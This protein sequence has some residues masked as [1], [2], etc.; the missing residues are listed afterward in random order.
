VEENWRRRQGGECSGG[1]FLEEDKENV[2]YR[3]WKESYEKE[4]VRILSRDSGQDCTR[5]M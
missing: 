5:K 4:K 3:R 2:Y 1:L